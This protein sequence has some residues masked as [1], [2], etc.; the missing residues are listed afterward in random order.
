MTPTLLTGRWTHERDREIAVFL[1]GMRVNRWW[2]V[3]HWWPSFI[4]FPRMMKALKMTPQG[5]L[6]GYLAV[7][8]NGIMY[9]QYWNSVDELLEFA[10]DDANIHPRTWR[11]YFERDRHDRGATGIWHETFVVPQGGTES[12][13]DHMPLMGL[14]AATTAV[15]V[16]RRSNTARQRLD[17]QG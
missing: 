4:A 13:Y 7:S 15:E 5:F 2:K 10:S 9:V 1:I 17:G 16:N 12:V 14:A 11:E 6:G 8:T 3:R